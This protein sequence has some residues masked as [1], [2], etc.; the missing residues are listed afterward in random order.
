MP[1]RKVGLNLTYHLVP[2]LPTAPCPLLPAFPT[3]ECISF[4][5]HPL[6]QTPV[7]I[8]IIQHNLPLPQYLCVHQPNSPK[9]GTKCF[10]TSGPQLMVAKQSQD[11]Y[12]AGDRS[13][14]T[15]LSQ[16]HLQVEHREPHGSLHSKQTKTFSF[17]APC[18]S[19]KRKDIRGT[20]W[21]SLKGKFQRRP[22]FPL[23]SPQTI[24]KYGHVCMDEC[25]PSSTETII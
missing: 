5:P 17:D 22:C 16:H 1:P 23:V 2:V 10:M 11:H 12:A 4:H 24:L 9:N 15:Y 6:L 14:V 25:N 19:Q 8:K 20:M 7:L 21:I 18:T 3:P 13:E